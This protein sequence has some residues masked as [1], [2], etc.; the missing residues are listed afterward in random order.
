LSLIPLE[1]KGKSGSPRGHYFQGTPVCL[2]SLLAANRNSSYL[3]SY[4]AIVRKYLHKEPAQI[5][6]DLVRNTPGE[7]GKWFS[8]AKDAGLLNLA[9]E[10]ANYSPCDPRTLARAA[11]DF[12]DEN[13]SFALEVGLAALSW[14]DKG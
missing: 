4:R 11:R 2:S 5:L 10:L 1:E 3:A 7:E 6:R 8:T 14:L 12:E 13:P 9:I